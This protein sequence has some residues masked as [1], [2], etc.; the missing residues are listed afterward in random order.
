M[1]FLGV[2]FGEKQGIVC[3]F[4]LFWLGFGR[5][6]GGELKCLDVWFGSSLVSCSTFCKIYILCGHLL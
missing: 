2:G 1:T 4:V 6:G 3:L 5:G